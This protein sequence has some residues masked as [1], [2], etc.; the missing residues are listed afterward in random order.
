MD[1][2]LLKNPEIIRKFEKLRLNLVNFDKSRLKML[3][4]C[5]LYW[6]PFEGSQ[7]H[8]GPDRVSLDNQN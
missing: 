3:P 1:E 7:D 2:I 5:S 4:V 8:E 6:E